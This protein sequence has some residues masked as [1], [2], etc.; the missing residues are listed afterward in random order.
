MV[1]SPNPANANPYP[2]HASKAIPFVSKTYCPAMVVTIL[3]IAFAKASVVGET[4]VWSLKMEAENPVATKPV[5]MIASGR[6]RVWRSLL[7]AFFRW[8]ITTGALP[9]GRC[10]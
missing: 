3:Y 9:Q 8:G 6:Y 5:K 1:Y 10:V 4:R 2:T 7:D